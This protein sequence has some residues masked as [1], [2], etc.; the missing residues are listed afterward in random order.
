MG[1]VAEDMMDGTIC[2]EC[3]SYFQGDKTDECHTH[4]YPVLCWDCWKDSK[5]RE[6][7]GFQR[8]TKPTL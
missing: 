1:Q 4:G 3:G 7:R 5:P 2:S 8:A 6:R